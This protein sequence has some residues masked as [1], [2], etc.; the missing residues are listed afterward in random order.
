MDTEQTPR[1]GTPVAL[2]VLGGL[3]VGGGLVLRS[4]LVSQAQS[5]ARTQSM[6]NDMVGRGGEVAP[7]YAHA[8]LTLWAVGAGVLI[9]A[10]ALLLT[11]TRRS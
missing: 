3:L 8:N 2:W 5:K 10:I 7:N 9:L 11:L 6:F 1:R 4:T